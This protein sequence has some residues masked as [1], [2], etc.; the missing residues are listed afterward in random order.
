MTVPYLSLVRRLAIPLALALLLPGCGLFGPSA[1]ENERT[2]LVD[3]HFDQFANMF[4]RYFPS[5]LTVRQ[6]DTAVFKQAW[7]GEAHTVSFGGLIDT[8]GK[9]IWACLDKDQ[10]APQDVL[11]G[12]QQAAQAIPFMVDQNNHVQQN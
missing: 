1:S 9:P 5:H 12:T 11:N 10:Q 2:V 4:A 7:N 6:G 8:I 3:Y